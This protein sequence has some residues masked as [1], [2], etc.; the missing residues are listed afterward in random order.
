MLII[1]KPKSRFVNFY[2]E[3]GDGS[4]VREEEGLIEQRR[5]EEDGVQYIKFV[6]LGEQKGT[7]KVLGCLPSECALK[8]ILSVQIL[9]PTQ[10]VEVELGS[11][12]VEGGKPGPYFWIVGSLIDPYAEF[13]IWNSVVQ[14]EQLG[15][16]PQFVRR[17]AMRVQQ[18]AFQ[19]PNS[20]ITACANRSVVIYHTENLAVEGVV[21]DVS[22]A[23]GTPLSYSSSE[24]K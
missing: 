24:F 2:I 7:Y 21:R 15:H 13:D 4:I 10:Q 1:N 19:Q 5:N 9:L 12:K 23:D 14:Q 20:L 3:K 22:T 16:C 17:L 18:A 11:L 6:N 8:S